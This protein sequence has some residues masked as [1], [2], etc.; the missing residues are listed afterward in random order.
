MLCCRETTLF[1]VLNLPPK[2]NNLAETGKI[3]LHISFWDADNLNVPWEK[4][5]FK[6]ASVA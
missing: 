3:Q 6:V 5:L 4:L 2:V 1:S